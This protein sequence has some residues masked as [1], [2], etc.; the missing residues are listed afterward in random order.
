MKHVASIKGKGEKVMKTYGVYKHPIKG[1]EVVKSGWSWPGFWFT[2]FWLFVKKI[3]GRAFVLLAVSLF[4]GVFVTAS[5]LPVI[6]LHFFGLFVGLYAGSA[7]NSWRINN[8]G[9]RGYKLRGV[10]QAR[11]SDEAS[12][13]VD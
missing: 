11:T 7:G 5:E 1:I 13:M 8:L 12:G 6:V 4:F 3:Y 2:I 10:V 9:K